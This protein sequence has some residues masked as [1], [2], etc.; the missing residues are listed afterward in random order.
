MPF[1]MS[2]L[3]C[4]VALLSLIGGSSGQVFTS[5]VTLAEFEY[6][7]A[8]GA[9]R[10][11]VS[12]DLGGL[13]TDFNKWQ[14]MAYA[15]SVDKLFAAPSFADSVLVINPRTNVADTTTLSRLGAGGAKWIGIAYAPV[16]NK[17]FC[18]PF[19]ATSVLIIDPVTN[20]TDTS[21]LGGLFG[22]G[23]QWRGIAFAPNTGKLY[24]APSN[25]NSVLIVDP[26]SNTT[27]ILIINP[28]T[29]VTNTS[30]MG[31]LGPNS[32]WAGI[33]YVASV[34][35]L[36][37]AP[38]DRNEVLVVNPRTNQTGLIAVPGPAASWAGIV[39]VPTTGL[40]FAAPFGADSVLIVNPTTNVTDTTTL[41]G[42]GVGGNKW[43]GIAFAPTVN[44]VIAAPYDSGTVLV[45]DP[46][47]NTTDTTTNVP[48]GGHKWLGI[49]YSPETDSLIAAPFDSGTVL[50][51]A[52]SADAAVVAPFRLIAA[53][54]GSID[55]EASTANAS[56]SSM[57]AGQSAL[58]S[59]VT[60]VV[61]DVSSLQSAYS[62][63]D[64]V[65][66]QIQSALRSSALEFPIR[67][68]RV[69]ALQ[70]SLSSTIVVQSSL[71]TALASSV[72]TQSVIQ[73]AQ[74]DLQVGLGNFDECH[75]QT[76][77]SG[78]VLD[79]TGTCVLD[80][81][82]LDRRG[83]VCDSHCTATTAI[84]SSTASGGG[85]SATPLGLIIGIVI[86]VAVAVAVIV[87]VSRRKDAT[88]VPRSTVPAQHKVSMYINP[89]HI[90]MDE[91][92]EPASPPGVNL[93]GGRDA[94]RS[95]VYAIPL[96]GQDT[97]VYARV[98]T[99]APS[100]SPTYST[101]VRNSPD[102]SYA[103]LQQTYGGGRPI[104]A[105]SHEYSALQRPGSHLEVTEQP[106]YAESAPRG[107]SG[108]SDGSYAALVRDSNTDHNYSSLQ[109]TYGG[110]SSAGRN[111]EYSTLN[112]PA[113]IVGDL[114]SASETDSVPR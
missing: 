93:G 82:D 60:G 51:I 28:S 63:T 72:S 86:A 16:V 102:T 96:E 106:Q 23:A 29:N 64:G 104:P 113:S 89:V 114:S 33:A 17:L 40:L 43:Q 22:Q 26:T 6:A 44:R 80:C 84:P 14:G 9:T 83:V 21:A 67:D 56:V 47:S 94:D 39:F 41:L 38:A 99:G 78:T 1:M 95:T 7:A 25:A 98:A 101:L 112:Q 58:A 88:A 81:P 61:A 50:R 71:R 54:R 8:L 13:G 97:P 92:A 27:T 19:S 103:S 75:I 18:A 11:L 68:A 42:F 76:C 53:L 52:F 70:N 31:G 69:R 49:A 12:T 45:I 3:S 2:Q 5:N 59:Q 111:T 15:P 55:A 109:R 20:T 65:Q 79:N 32:R 24:A 46:V 66:Q 110:G 74:R 30:T 108:P 77:A 100:A 4:C 107:T 85:S 48:S 87:V 10:T 35:M 73:R 57:R 105:K 34:D 62:L 90:G 91:F 37:A 36:F